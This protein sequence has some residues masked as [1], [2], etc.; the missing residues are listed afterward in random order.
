MFRYACEKKR[1]V[2]ILKFRGPPKFD[3]RTWLKLPISSQ[4]TNPDR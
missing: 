2:I 4:Y 3:F 1:T